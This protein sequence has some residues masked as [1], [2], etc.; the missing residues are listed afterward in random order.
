MITP[1][2]LKIADFNYDLQKEKIALFPCEKKKTLTLLIY[3]NQQIKQD[4]FAHIANHLP[5]IVL[6]FNNTVLYMRVC[7]YEKSTEP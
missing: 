1:I 5:M 3:E 4:I 7:F 2:I 6:I